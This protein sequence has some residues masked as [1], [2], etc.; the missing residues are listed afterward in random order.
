MPTPLPANSRDAGYH[1]AAD[2]CGFQIGLKQELCHG[3]AK[4]P[5]QLSAMLLPDGALQVIVGMDVFFPAPE[6]KLMCA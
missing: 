2:K 1:S 3:K 4:P 5:G 6:K